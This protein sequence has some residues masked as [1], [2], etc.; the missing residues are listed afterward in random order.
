MSFAAMTVDEESMSRISM[1]ALF[2]SDVEQKETI[3]FS[4][5]IESAD[6]DTETTNVYDYT[7]STKT[8]AL[9][10]SFNPNVGTTVDHVAYS[11]GHICYEVGGE[12]ETKYHVVSLVTG[13]KTVYHKNALEGFIIWTPIVVN[14]NGFVAYARVNV[15]TGEIAVNVHKPAGELRLFIRDIPI[16][17]MSQR[18]TLMFTRGDVLLLYV[19]G[20]EGFYLYKITIKD[21]VLE[22]LRTG[23]L[24]PR[25]GE[26]GRLELAAMHRDL[27]NM[28]EFSVLCCEVNTHSLFW[29]EI[30]DTE[31]GFRLVTSRNARRF[32]SQLLVIS[33]NILD[34]SAIVREEGESNFQLIFADPRLEPL[35]WDNLFVEHG[36]PLYSLLTI[37]GV[38]DEDD[39]ALYH[40]TLDYVDLTNLHLQ[41]E[42]IVI[43]PPPD[44]AQRALFDA[45]QSTAPPPRNYYC[46]LLTALRSGDDGEVKTTLHSIPEHQYEKVVSDMRMV[47]RDGGVRLDTILQEVRSASAVCENEIDPLSLDAVSDLDDRIEIE[48]GGREKSKCY[49]K[50]YVVGQIQN[51]PDMRQWVQNPDANPM[52]GEGYGGMPSGVA[53]R[54]VKID[55]YWV[56]R[57][58]PGVVALL[59]DGSAVTKFQASS[60]ATRQRIGNAA[61][62]F[63]ISQ[64]HGQLPGVTIYDLAVVPQAPDATP[65]VSTAAASQAGKKR[66][67]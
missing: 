9:V 62:T 3:R 33:Y 57:N 6:G 54:V 65:Q 31:T 27:L 11:R 7:A 24:N 22:A 58:S 51:Q 8:V 26:P 14:E 16:T 1:L 12:G 48:W 13:V 36:F 2:R 66:R 23:T 34:Q 35:H 44:A 38:D 37:V 53:T 46:E 55:T 56:R 60:I 40:F 29:G 39:D 4:Q 15:G 61:G 45:R 17:D 21:H 28:R 47:L 5:F 63:G 52:D 30:H 10:H 67:L 20:P 64:L 43:G 59:D 42:E 32:S 25:D 18:L 41:R 50:M 19:P 49:S